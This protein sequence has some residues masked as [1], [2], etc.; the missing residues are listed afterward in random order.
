MWFLKLIFFLFV[1]VPLMALAAVLLLPC[2]LIKSLGY[3]I[4]LFFTVV[5]TL[6]FIPFQVI[7]A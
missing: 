3:L 7:F 5:T 4:F 1:A 6:L 2:Y